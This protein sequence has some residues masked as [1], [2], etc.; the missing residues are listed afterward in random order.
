MEA[1]KL[2]ILH[3][4][5]LE[6]YPPVTNLLDFMASKSNVHTLCISTHSVKSY[7]YKK[8]VIDVRRYGSIYKGKVLRIFSY[9][10]YNLSSLIHL[11]F[12][13]PDAILYYESISSWPAYLYKVFINRHVRVCIH[14]HEY[15]QPDEYLNGMKLVQYFH[16]REKNLYPQAEWISHTNETRM[17]KF[18]ENENLKDLKSEVIKILPNFPPKSWLTK[19]AQKNVNFPISMIYVGYSMDFET[20]YTKEVLEWVGSMGGKVELDC[21]LHMPNKRVEKYVNEKDIK[22][23]NFKRSI[24]YERLPEKLKNYNVGLILYKGTFDNYKYNAPNK[25]FEYLVCGLDV[26]FP[27]EMTGCHPFINYDTYPRVVNLDFNNL[28]SIAIS[29]LI[30]K[31]SK[32]YDVSQFNYENVYEHFYHVLIKQPAYALN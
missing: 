32:S 5:P 8:E 16:T 27:D 30:S 21:F 28:N 20:M 12:E 24:E 14:Y 6:N 11:I 17:E 29:N 26:W 22:H 31:R 2:V 3:F 13:K 10:L 9:L 7:S 15:V 4:R 18:L 1:I 25:L 23:V 19:R